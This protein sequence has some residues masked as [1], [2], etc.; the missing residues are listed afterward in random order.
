M[1]LVW[2]KQGPLW[3]QPFTAK[4]CWRKVGVKQTGFDVGSIDH[5]TLVNDDQSVGGSNPSADLLAT[6]PTS[7]E[8]VGQEV[9]PGPLSPM[10]MP[11]LPATVRKGSTAAYKFLQESAIKQRDEARREIKEM[12][13]GVL[14]LESTK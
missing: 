3:C 7:M 14:T 5:S 2:P 6:Q 12:Q 9:Q 11:A 10:K 4:G 8:V 13:A 1:A